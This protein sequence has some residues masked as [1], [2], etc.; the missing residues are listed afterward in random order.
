MKYKLVANL[1][2]KSGVNWIF[3]HTS[4]EKLLPVKAIKEQETINII[5][6]F[7]YHAAKI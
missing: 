6:F 4:A 3:K 7:R 1:N 2:V 5:I